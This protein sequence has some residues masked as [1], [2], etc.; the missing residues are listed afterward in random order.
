ME[1]SGIGGVLT[2]VFLQQTSGAQR[3]KTEHHPQEVILR[4][5]IGKGHF[6]YFALIPL[7][8]E[9][10]HPIVLYYPCNRMPKTKRESAGRHCY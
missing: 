5:S 6:T 9:S 2:A 7:T 3:K 1:I 8:Y 10:T 4:K